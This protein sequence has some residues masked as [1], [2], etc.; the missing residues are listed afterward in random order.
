MTAQ[1]WQGKKVFLTGHTGFKGSWL[2]M[3]LSMLGAEVR[4]FALAPDSQ[5]NLFEQA[6]LDTL[7]DSRLGD[8]RQADALEAC[9]QD[10]APD[11]VLHLAAQAI[12]STSYQE[13]IA[14]LATNVLGTAHVLEAIR[15]TPSVRAAVI[16]TTDKCYDNAETGQLF[17]ET[18]PLGGKDPYSASKACAELVTASWC[19]SFFTGTDDH[20]SQPVVVTA[21]AGNVIG[22][23]DW[24]ANRL[25]P[26]I[27]R[28][29]TGGEPA[30]IRSPEAIR[31]WQHVLEPLSGY[32]LLAQRCC[33]DPAIARAWNFG[34]DEDDAR[35][36][37]DIAD[38]L[39]SCWGGQASWQQ[40]G[41]NPVKEAHSL[42]L[43]S[44][45]ARQVLGW[46]PKTDLQEGLRW[47][48]DWYRQY[49]EGRPAADI[50]REQIRNYLDKDQPMHGNN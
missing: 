41:S 5:P 15:N 7:L 48:A 2:S 12:V 8:I 38:T 10:F 17:R 43:D 27:M 18:D 42:R 33:N 45:R 14:T 16:V 35:P 50:C 37:R 11:V 6:K 29:F 44:S 21:R 4:G 32:L 3:M 22:G 20:E 24:S 36:V 13:P 1:F 39:A 9:M 34:P 19:E 23:G 31:P 40:T 30:L 47:T 46:Q 26:D 25:V 28:A 49:A